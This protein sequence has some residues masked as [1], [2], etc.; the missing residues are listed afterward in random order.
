MRNTREYDFNVYCPENDV[1]T[2]SAYKLKYVGEGLYTTDH[3]D[4]TTIRFNKNLD[5]HK[6]CV[7]WLLSEVDES[8]IYEDLDAWDFTTEELEL[9]APDPICNWVKSLPYYE[10]EEDSDLITRAK[11]IGEPW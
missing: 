7:E 5:A 2:L 9:R 3:S 4:W 10:V 1:I 6:E 11:E 8:E